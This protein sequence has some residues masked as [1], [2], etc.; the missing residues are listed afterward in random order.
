MVGVAAEHVL[1]LDDATRQLVHRHPD[2][3][4]RRERGE[5]DLDAVLAPAVLG[6]APGASCRPAT[7]DV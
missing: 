1:E 4:A 3:P 6:D 7:N 2:E 5:P